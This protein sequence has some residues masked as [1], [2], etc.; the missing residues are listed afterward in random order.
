MKF[1]ITTIGI[2]SRLKSLSILWKMYAYI[3]ISCKSRLFRIGRHLMVTWSF[4]WMCFIWLRPAS[5][6]LFSPGTCGWCCSE[7]AVSRCH[8]FLSGR[9]SE[10][11]LSGLNLLWC[12]HGLPCVTSHTVSAVLVPPELCGNKIQIMRKFVGNYAHKKM[13]LCAKISTNFAIH[14][15][16]IYGN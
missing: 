7:R 11:Q 15:T 12:W 8:I 9:K 10:T 2:L 1:K 14:G 3:Y 4:S 5:L 16:D 13:K 6:V